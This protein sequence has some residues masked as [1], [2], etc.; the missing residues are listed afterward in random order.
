MSSRINNGNKKKV[1]KPSYKYQLATLL[2]HSTLFCL[3]SVL[4]LL[5]TEDTFTNKA[6][7][8]LVASLFVLLTGCHGLFLF[9]VHCLCTKEFYHICKKFLFGIKSL[10]L[11]TVRKKPSPIDRNETVTFTNQYLETKL[12]TNISHGMCCF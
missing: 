5:M 2:I 1:L 12:N 7:R 8:D 4:M 11:H 9:V 10:S 6:I 3:S